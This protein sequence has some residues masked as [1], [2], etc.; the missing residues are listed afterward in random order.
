MKKVD[1]NT[2]A[3]WLREK[4]KTC[5]CPHCD[6][7]H[8]MH[9]FSWTALDCLNPEC[10]KTV[11][12][13]D[14]NLEVNETRHLETNLRQLKR[15]QKREDKRWEPNQHLNSHMRD[16]LDEVVDLLDDLVNYDPTPL[17]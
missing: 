15:I 7:A 16:Q 2:R 14:W 5:Y 10:K 1:R 17:Y 9:S 3:P 8:R 4:G 13:Y 11:K 6:H 12:K